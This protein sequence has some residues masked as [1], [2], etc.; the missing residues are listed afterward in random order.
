[1]ERRTLGRNGIEVPVIGMGTWKTFDTD[2][3]RVPIVDEA[4]AAGVDLFDSSPMYGKA[5]VTLAAALRGRREKALVATKVWT[6]S[7]EEGRRQAEHALELFG[8]IDIYQVHNLVAVEVQLKLLE[9]L[10]EEGRVRTIGATHY[11]AHAFPELMQLMR[12]GRLG[13][14]QV[15][16][17]PLRQ[18]VTK[19]VLP[20]AQERGL[21]VLVMSPLQY[22]VLDARPTPDELRELAVKT[23]SEAVLKWIV[24]DPRV[25]CVLTATQRAGRITANARAGDRP[26]YTREQR[27]LVERIASR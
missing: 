17:N 25:T 13:M 3:D 22:G 10:R 5:E 12:T 9:G 14:I 20:L 4:L 15:P 8:H 16:Y 2:D 11:Q 18:E 24:S 19:A 23:W 27:S 1:V 7:A 6:D 21:G 26:F